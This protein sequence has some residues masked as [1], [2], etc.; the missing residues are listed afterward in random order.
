MK[1]EH[2]VRTTHR[3]PVG[4]LRRTAMCLWRQAARSL[5]CPT[6]PRLDGTVALV[7]G[8][9]RG[10]GLAT[11][12]G[13]AMRGADVITASRG[14]ATGGQIAEELGRDLETLSHFVP[15]DLGDLSQIEHCVEALAKHLGDQRLQIVI[16]NAGL[17]PTRH[18]VSAQGHELAFATNAL[19]HH[20]LLRGLEER[21][22][23]APKATIVIVTGDIYIL[24]RSCPPDF[25]FNGASG[26]QRAYCQSKLGNLWMMREWARRRPHLR[27]HAVHPGVVDSGLAG[28][29]AGMAARIKRAML[30]NLDDGAQ[31]SLYCATQ[32]GLDSGTYYHNTMGLVELRDDDP[33]ADAAKA[34][35]FWDLLERLFVAQTPNAGAWGNLDP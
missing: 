27:V 31:T 16:A 25:E 4:T 28:P 29:S 24:S 22:L 11:S 19:G 23:L 35:E 2:S 18:A 21:G 17:W 34:E 26:G 6:G 10:I 15:L 3:P 12:R 14:K 32:P 9:M 30:L 13:L 5:Q 7:T 20:A 8:G 1:L 33:A